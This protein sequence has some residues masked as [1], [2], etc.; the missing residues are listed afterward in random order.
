PGRAG[1]PRRRGRGN[2]QAGGTVMHLLAEP[3]FWVLVAFV[4]FVAVMLRP[5]RRA[6]LAALDKRALRIKSQIEE[7]ERLRDDA[8]HL[9]AEH[10][11]KQRQALGEAEGILS[12]A[13]AEAERHRGR[14][15]AELDAALKSR[16]QQAMDR[17]AQAE[18][19][20][21]AEVR[22]AAVDVAVAAT[23]RLLRDKLDTRKQDEL[24]GQAIKELPEKVH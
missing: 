19:Q 16:E 14:A 7:A 6:A 17:I 18:A 4:V 11:R 9:L 1:A 22:G 21:V 3:E 5:I 20:A 23:R 2:P 10:E 12:R 13:R 15:A 24:I 8:Q